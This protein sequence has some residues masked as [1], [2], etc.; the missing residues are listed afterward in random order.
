MKN[1]NILLQGRNISLRLITTKDISDYFKSGFQSI[2]EE[3]QRCTGTKHIPTVEDI[4]A[5]VNRIVQDDLRYDFLMID[6]EGQIIGES[7]INEINPDTGCANFR[8]GIFKSENFGHGIG[9]EA[10][11]MTIKF[12]FEELN[13]HRIELE[14]F[15]FNERAYRAYRRA[16]FIEEGRLREAELIDGQYCDVTIMGILHDD[17][18]KKEKSQN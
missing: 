15:S 7:V 17:Y 1:N 5:Y 2:D 16:G 8:I 11:A 6:S 14:V 4:T 13:L 18:I 3:T 9:S 10:I 12:G